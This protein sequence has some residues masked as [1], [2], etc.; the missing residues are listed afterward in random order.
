M[1]MFN[2]S[3][4]WMEISIVGGLFFFFFCSPFGGIRLL[5]GRRSHKRILTS[6]WWHETVR[7]KDRASAGIKAIIVYNYTTR[8][9]LIECHLLVSSAVDHKWGLD[10]E[11]NPSPVIGGWKFSLQEAVITV[12][13][14]LNATF[15]IF[16]VKLSLLPRHTSRGNKVCTRHTSCLNIHCHRIFHIYIYFFLLCTHFWSQCRYFLCEQEQQQPGELLEYLFHVF[17]SRGNL[18]ICS[19]ER[20]SHV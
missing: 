20:F 13:T 14:V 4:L 1:N 16:K 9:P 8:R 18:L 19:Q 10:D 7:E 17:F 12:F 15:H 2:I 11:I 3:F 6:C 5:S